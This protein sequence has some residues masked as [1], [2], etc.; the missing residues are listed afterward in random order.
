VGDLWFGAAY[1]GIVPLFVGLCGRSWAVV[2]DLRVGAAGFAASLALLAFA[3]DFGSLWAILGFASGGFGLDTRYVGSHSPCSVHTR[4]GRSPQI[5]W[6]TCTIC[7]F[8]TQRAGSATSIPGGHGCGS[9]FCCGTTR[10]S[11]KRGWDFGEND[12]TGGRWSGIGGGNGAGVLCF[13]R[14]T[15]KQTAATTETTA[16]TEEQRRADG[17]PRARPLAGARFS[18]VGI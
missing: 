11:P 7:C 5:V 8:C 2:G 16:L 9:G 1:L 6:L 3:G 14:M 10:K 15:A 4:E 17:T 18:S 12:G 13:G